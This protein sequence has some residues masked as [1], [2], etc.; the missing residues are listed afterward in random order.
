MDVYYEVINGSIYVCNRNHNVKTPANIQLSGA[1]I[2]T[3]Q[4]QEI[5]DTMNAVYRAGWQ[6]AMNKVRALVDQMEVT[7]VNSKKMGH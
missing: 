1:A 6:Q 4:L 2:N 3:Q 5:C 7:C